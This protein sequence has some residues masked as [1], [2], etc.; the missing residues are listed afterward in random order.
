[1]LNPKNAGT[2]NYEA[3]TKHLTP[4]E[5]IAAEKATQNSHYTS[6]AV[7]EAIY[8]GLE[9]LG[10]KG[11]RVLEPSAGVGHFLGLMPDEMRAGSKWRAVEKD[12]LTSRILKQLYQSAAVDHSPYEKLR[13]PENHFDLIVSN[14]PFGN[15]PITDPSMTAKGVDPLIRNRIHN[16][17]FAKALDQVRPGGIV[18]FITS[19]GTLN[20]RDSVAMATRKHLDEHAK[21]LGAVR[22]PNTAFLRNAGTEVTTDILFLQKRSPD[23]FQIRDKSGNVVRRDGE[24]FLQS[25]E[26]DLP[27]AEGNLVKGHVNEYFLKHPEMVIGEH[28]MA[29]KMRRGGGAEYATLPKEG[30]DLATAVSEAMERLPE[31]VY[32]KVSREQQMASDAAKAER[33]TN[34]G[35]TGNL[36]V[37]GGKV[38]VQEHDGTAKAISVGPEA[39]PVIESFSTLRD[40]LNETVAAMKRPRTPEE[41]AQILKGEIPADV[42]A[43]QK[44]LKAAYDAYT[45]KYGVL[46]ARQGNAKKH[47]IFWEED[48]DSYAVRGLEKID[49]GTRKVS[50]LTDIFTK[51]VVRPIQ[52]AAVAD[53]PKDAL[54]A[55]LR[56]TAKIDPD[57][58]ASLT[59]RKSAEILQSLEED[60]LIYHDPT[61]GEYVTAEEYGSG[62]VRAKLEAAKAAKDER[63]VKFLESVQPELLKPG[64]IRAKLGATWVPHD[65]YKEFLAHLLGKRADDIMLRYVPIGSKWHAETWKDY[66]STVARTKTWGTGRMDAVD[67]FEAAMNG[68]M[69]Q[70]FDRDGDAR[71]LNKAETE[72]AQNKLQAIQN[73]WQGWIYRDAARADSLAEKYNREVNVYAPRKYDGSHLTFPGQNPLAFP[74]GLRE[75]QKNAIWRILQG[76]NALLAHDVGAGKT[77]VIITSAME[78]RRMGIRNKPMIVVKKSG[79]GQMASDFKRQYPAAKILVADEDTIGGKRREFMARIATGDWDSVILTHDALKRLPVHPETEMRYLQEEIDRV[80]EYLYTIKGEGERSPTVK[81]VSKILDRLEAKMT[82]RRDKIGSI[83]DDAVYWDDLG[84]DQVFIDE[85]HKYKKLPV[86]SE[87]PGVTDKGSDFATDLLLKTSELQKNGGSVVFATGTPL[88]NSVAEMHGLLRFLGQDLLKEQGTAN[89]DDWARNF[90]TGET[91]LEPDVAGVYKP[92]FRF[93]TFSNVPE[94]MQQYLSIADVVHVED[95]AGIERPRLTDREGT[96]TDKPIVVET[97]SSPAQLAYFKQMVARAKDLPHPPQPGDDTMLAISTDGR[98]VSLDPRT[99]IRGAEDYPNS[100]INGVV[101]EVFDVYDNP[102]YKRDRRAQ[103]VF[104]D[105]G[106]PGNPHFD[107]YADVKAKLVKMGVNP[108][109]IAFI[110]QF[111]TDAKKEALSEAVREG[112]TRIVIGSREMM[113]VGLNVQDRLVAVHQV[114]PPWRPDQIEQSNGRILRQG[115]IPEFRDKG[116]RIYNYVNK[117]S[118]DE[119]MWNKVASKEK[120]IKQVTKGDTGAREIEDIS[121]DEKFSFA[122]MQAAATGNPKISELIKTSAEVK[123]LDGLRQS[124]ASAVY[125]MRRDISTIENISIP[126]IERQQ[127]AIEGAISLRDKTVPEEFSATVGG[128]TF[129]GTK[130]ETQTA[131]FDA[132]EKAGERLKTYGQPEPVGT[133][134]GFQM[135]LTKSLETGRVWNVEKKAYD[136]IAESV[137]HLTLTDPHGRW[138]DSMVVSKGIAAKL[139]NALHG[140]EGD[141][142]AKRSAETTYREQIP[143][144]Q[145]EAAKPFP[146]EEQL[147][148]AHAKRAELEKEVGVAIEG[149]QQG[150]GAT[151]NAT[152]NALYQRTETK[153]AAEPVAPQSYRIMDKGRT[154]VIAE[155]QSEPLI[156]RARKMGYVVELVEA[157]TAKPA[158]DIYD[159]TGKKVIAHTESEAL[160]SQALA[161]GR[162]VVKVS[163]SPTRLL[164]KEGT[165]KASIEFL[166]ADDKSVSAVVKLGQNA[167][168]SSFLHEVFHYSRRQMEA[169]SGTNERVRA[170]F[171]TLSEWSG[172]KKSTDGWKWSESAEE[173]SARAWERYLRE[174]K[175]PTVELRDVFARIKAWMVQIYKRIKGSSLDV[176]LT[177]EVRRVFDRMLGAE[178]NVPTKTVQ[179]PSADVSVPTRTVQKPPED[180]PSDVT[181]GANII[182]EAERAKRN[183]PPVEKQAYKLVSDSVD[184][185]KSVVESGEVNPTLVARSV[186]ERPRV[187]SVEEVNGLVYDRMRLINQHEATQAKIAGAVDDGDTHT[188]G[189][190]SARLAEIERDLD[191]NDQA[192][193]KGGREQSAAFAARKALIAQDYSYA[194]MLQR[195]KTKKGAPLT[196]AERVRIEELHKQIAALSG[197]VDAHAKI[198]AELEAAAKAE[199]AVR[200]M[201]K[202]VRPREP[203]EPR[204]PKEGRQA[205]RTNIREIRNIHDID[206][207]ASKLGSKL[208][209]RILHQKEPPSVLFQFGEID[210]EDVQI[211]QQMAKVAVENGLTDADVIVKRVHEA[212]EPYLEGVDEAEVRDAISGYGNVSESTQDPIELQLQQAKR[213]M[214]LISQLEDVSAGEKPKASGFRPKPDDPNVTALRAQLSEA[215][216]A[217]GMREPWSMTTEQRQSAQATRLKA[218]IEE[219]NRRIG[220]SDFSKPGKRPSV[221]ETPETAKLKAERDRLMERYD[222]MAGPTRL[223]E[224]LAKTKERMAE[225]IKAYEQAIEKKERIPKKERNDLPYDPALQRLLIQQERYKASYD[226]MVTRMGRSRAQRLLYGAADVLNLPRT[227]M[228]GLFDASMP[229]RQGWLLVLAHPRT[230]VKAVGKGYAAFVNPHVARRVE[231][232]A[233]EGPNAHRYHDSGLYLQPSDLSAPVSAKAE[234]YQSGL[235]GKIP[236]IRHGVAASSRSAAASMNSLRMDVFDKLTSLGERMGEKDRAK[237]DKAIANGINKLSGRGSLGEKA[238]ASSHLLNVF[239]FSARYNASRVQVL[240]G[241]SLWTGT[242]R[243]R[244]VLLGEYAK[245]AAGIGAILYLCHQ[246]GADVEGDLRHPESLK[247][248]F[249]SIV[250]DVG[251][252]LQQWLTFAARMVKGSTVTSAGKEDNASD[253]R[254]RTALR[255]ARSKASPVAGAAWDMLTGKD[256]VGNK[257]SSPAEAWEDVTQGKLGV[258]DVLN[259]EPV[260][261]MI[262][263]NSADVAEAAEKEGVPPAVLVF[264]LGFNGIGVS[265]YPKG[266]SESGGS[267]THSHSKS[268]DRPLTGSMP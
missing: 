33:I 125:D 57:L 23:D 193:Q 205:R 21:L 30:V 152:E 92:K 198:I 54:I 103:L 3:L 241:E 206:V 248:R 145:E 160:V 56:R 98:H 229:G 39:P 66:G 27:D 218:R 208:G 237:F 148:A 224:R 216:K 211:L 97:K 84:V 85:S 139:R 5:R 32:K 163:E 261:L 172:A 89:F 256:F 8:K 189:I 217:A 137:L 75:H 10:F 19:E 259:S 153:P 127:K 168:I 184:R 69:P 183:L 9:R 238:N 55:S 51:M 162:K 166:P 46:N 140:L 36:I 34:K 190:E 252:G 20:A 121:G 194:G 175:A 243:S 126:T 42:A 212:A 47:R 93:S 108:D 53:T 187:L 155:T 45:K 260:K 219:L 136:S 106:T 226:E 111:D 61:T 83:Q 122:E 253:V 180:V 17:F 22:L 204:E 110:Q 135:A 191:L 29:G 12:S 150:W 174:G 65:V 134:G 227:M 171:D 60:G 142:K 101:R 124:H 99:R 38:Y 197:Q 74:K 223:L 266:G 235:A 96:F 176:D 50:G 58:M 7:I 114:D 228:A 167:D 230:G 182:T 196:E 129:T 87:Y 149:M 49:R 207:L 104:M 192:L 173:K 159:A 62:N 156:E 146:Q 170:D 131:L 94:M 247:M 115:M 200:R 71:V 144:L 254:E 213:A 95:V 78:M 90:V 202:E 157:K 13:I 35:R 76:G 246:A 67:L 138:A 77:A 102:Q 151:E 257:V 70:V 244:A 203:R 14:V 123:R 268:S 240:A 11:G 258:S 1:M 178:E 262:P 188:Q 24:A 231:L 41:Y 107:L 117:G 48:P 81:E 147:K 18:A 37:K 118:F 6:P 59:G 265:Y 221:P 214:R 255:F 242:V 100:K 251:A 245:A 250:I 236:G 181:G 109:E 239:L 234:D 222:E 165:P 132:L 185:G 232:R 133:Y 86:T 63:H 112:K 80:R 4:E 209:R 225:R 143:K 177:D 113:G 15:I 72:A 158:W 199:R 141:L 128:K 82:E 91:S 154:R 105:L 40:T 116:V 52:E 79:L 64:Q 31:G 88:T 25:V 120:F 210:P 164:Q 161:K 201:E 179:K 249:G 267:T 195:A 16:Y 263:M 68:R 44:R 220:V 264:L 233:L 130:E 186:A 43:L 119:F 169:T 73:E 28:S 2:R 215:L 26:V